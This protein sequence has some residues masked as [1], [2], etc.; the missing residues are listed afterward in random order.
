LEIKGAADAKAIYYWIEW[1][2]TNEKGVDSIVNIG[3]PTEEK[4]FTSVNIQGYP[5]QTA[6]ETYAKVYCNG[7]VFTSEKIKVENAAAIA[8]SKV[9]LMGLEIFIEHGADS[10]ENYPLYD[11]L[12]NRLFNLGEA[13]RSRTLMLNYKSK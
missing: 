11:G 2:S 12:T 10:K 7:Q 9:D 6:I 3:T 4:E 13:S 8:Q 1:Y 5:N